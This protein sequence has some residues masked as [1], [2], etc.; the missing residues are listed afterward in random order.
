MTPEELNQGI[1]RL[2]NLTRDF[3]ISMAGCLIIGIPCM[4]MIDLASHTAWGTIALFPYFIAFGTY[5]WKT[6]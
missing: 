3:I 2:K 5:L 4:I 1:E 6:R